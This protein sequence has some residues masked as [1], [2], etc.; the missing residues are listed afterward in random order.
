VGNNPVGLSKKIAIK[1]FPDLGGA[2]E[3]IEITTLEDSIRKF[4]V[5]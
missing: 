5:E 1:G 4:M 3:T 2:P